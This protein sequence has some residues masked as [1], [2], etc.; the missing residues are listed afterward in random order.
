LD[1]LFDELKRRNVIRVAVAYLIASWL[2]MQVADIVLEAILAPAW[3]M[4]VFLLIVS[5]GPM[6]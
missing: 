5:P 4:Q 3:V 1:K 2:V 6:N